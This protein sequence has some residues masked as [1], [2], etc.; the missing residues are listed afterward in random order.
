MLQVDQHEP[1]EKF[2]QYVRPTE[3]PCEVAV[4]NERLMADYRWKGLDGRYTQ[5]ERKQWGEILASVD[6]VEDQLRRH[7]KNQPEDRLLLIIEGMFAEDGSGVHVLSAAKGGNI[8][9]KGYRSGT[10]ISRVYSWLYNAS[11]Y[12]EVFQ[13]FSYELTCQFLV[14]AYKQDQK[15][16]SQ[17]KT[18][19]RYFKKVTFHP[20]PQVLALIGMAPG[21]GEVRAEALIDKFTTVWR[22]MN[23][24]PG[25][26]MQVDGIGSGLATT[27]LQRIGRTDV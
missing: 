21:L 11:E 19:N 25:E 26:L 13:T 4:L 23:A 15:E 22:V 10:R 7:L 18:F 27:F 24:S 9:V 16:E 12:V 6:S 8:W 14:Q 17:H 1:T 20:N 3:V 5:V 2:L